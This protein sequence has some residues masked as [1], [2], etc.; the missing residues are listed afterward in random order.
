MLTLVL[1][2]D[3]PE[4]EIGLYRGDEQLAY[5]VWEAHRHLAETLHHKIKEV[6]ESQ[7]QSLNGLEGIVVFKGPGSFTGLRIG[8]TVANALAK[9]L[10]LPIVAEKG[11]TWTT[12]GLEDL[13]AGKND[14]LALPEYG[15]PVHIT[16][17]KK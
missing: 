15:A 13:K 8:L 4:A 12:Q 3:K 1:R 2:T 9:S 14:V 7:G 16:S 17:P 5:V 10:N 6:L 11:E